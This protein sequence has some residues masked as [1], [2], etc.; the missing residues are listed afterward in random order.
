TST[1]AAACFSLGGF[2]SVA[3]WPKIIDAMVWLPLIVLFSLRAFD[4]DRASDRLFNAAR[5][6]ASLGMTLLAGSIHVTIMDGLVVATLAVH[7]G[8]SRSEKKSAR[9]LPAVVIVVV[10]VS[11]LVGGFQVLATFDL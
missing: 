11:A 9:G 6:G 3:A 1:V 8:L 7:V 2:M 5:A 4:S 10:A